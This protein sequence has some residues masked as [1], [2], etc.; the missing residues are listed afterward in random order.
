[1]KNTLHVFKLQ[2]NLILVSKFLSNGLKV[3]INLKI[4]GVRGMD[5]DMTAMEL[6]EGNLYDRNFSKTCGPD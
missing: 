3:Q 4:Y 1:M 2:V 5:G 6:R